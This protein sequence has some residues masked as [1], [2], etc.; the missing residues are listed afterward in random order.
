[1]RLKKARIQKYRSV[2]DTGDFDVEDQKTI[3]VGPNEA[4]KSAVLQ[5]LQQINAPTGVPG[6]DPLR[7]YPRS[8]YNADIVRG[9]IEPKDITVAEAEFSLEEKDWPV[10]PPE[11]RACT[12][13]AGRTLDNKS[14]FQLNG[15]PPDPTFGDVKRDLVQLAAYVDARV[16]T[17]AE[18]T[19]P[20]PL[21]SAT[22]KTATAAWTDTL[23]LDANSSASLRSLVDV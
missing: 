12:F 23:V 4:G 22:L 11:F 13:S 16:P 15:G 20:P 7:D 8:L 5:A 2:I 18:G 3:L 14:W 9:K 10:V 6:F 1:M 19:S 17:P 21:P